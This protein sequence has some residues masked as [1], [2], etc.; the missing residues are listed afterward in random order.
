MTSASDRGPRESRMASGAD[1]G[2]RENRMAGSPDPL[3]GRTA[4]VTGGA[5]RLGRATAL[6]L[7]E[8]G[9]HVGVHYLASGAEAE[10]TAAAI[11]A[12][13]VRAVALPADLGQP[14][15]LE[16][17]F[18]RAVEALGPIDILINNASIF[19]AAR[20]TEVS[21]D[22][23]ERNLRVNALG[24]F[25]LAR[26]LAAQQR[27]ASVVNFL[28]TRVLDYDA[29]HVA[30]HLS[31]R[32]LFDLTRMM[33]LEFAPAVRVNGVAPGLILPPRGEDE[34]YLARLAHTNPLQ[35]YGGPDD[36]VAAVLFLLRSPFITGQIIYIDGG[37]H[38]RG[39]VYG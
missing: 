18:G 22:E 3:R 10:E 12:H 28:D 39:A 38:M 29:K 27:P 9:V 8:A 32:M 25:V 37:R 7:A 2:T 30:Y 1:Q 5:R 14:A 33:A 20:L 4:L 31:K 35:R 36:V 16:S 21:V 24:P 11:R 15:T 19:P 17:F 23:I 26:A 6:A 34:A 13:G